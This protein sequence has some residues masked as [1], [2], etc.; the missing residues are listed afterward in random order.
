MIRVAAITSGKNV[1]SARFRI[2]QHIFPLREAGV[3]V[4]EYVPAV[5]KYARFPNLSLDLGKRNFMPVNALWWGIKLSTRVPAVIGSWTAQITWLERELCPG[6]LTLELM[7]KRP[8]VF[9]VD[10]PIWL[11][12][13]FGRSAAIRIANNAEVVLAGNNYIAEWIQPH[14]KDRPNRPNGYR[15]RTF[16]GTSVS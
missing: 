1:P 9:D 10:D 2:R 16:F 6:Y 12:L 8:Y 3:E 13:P 7:L 15:Y 4:R 14:A 11:G 5:D